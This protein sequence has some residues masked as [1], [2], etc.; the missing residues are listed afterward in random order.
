MSKVLALYYSSYS[1]I[2]TIAQAAAEGAREVGPMSRSNAFPKR[3]RAKRNTGWIRPRSQRWTTSWP[4]M[5]RRRGRHALRPLIVAEGSFLDRASGLWMHGALH[6]E[7]GG[8]FT[9]RNTAGR[10]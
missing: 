9:S 4:T 10:K 3:S 1:H 6:G 7:V 8:A 2:E 5:P